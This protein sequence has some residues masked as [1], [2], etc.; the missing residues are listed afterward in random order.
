MG[1]AFFFWIAQVLASSAR[2]RDSHSH[3]TKQF[4]DSPMQLNRPKEGAMFMSFAT[5]ESMF[6]YLGLRKD[7]RT[8]EQKTIDHTAT[9][10]Q[11]EDLKPNFRSM[12]PERF[13]D[14]Q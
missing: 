14:I 10:Q 6:E 12:P 2:W 5:S 7:T 1:T 4:N 8:P 9:V 3:P 13:P 11:G